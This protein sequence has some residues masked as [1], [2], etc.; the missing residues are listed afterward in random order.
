MERKG[1]GRDLKKELVSAESR[2]LETGM[3][4]A[5]SNFEPEI[6]IWGVK[7]GEGG[8]ECWNV[9]ATL[10]GTHTLRTLKKKC[11]KELTDSI[12]NW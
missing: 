4:G 12:P 5:S 10:L 8:L 3:R 11:I 9:W 2:R 7:E 6:L 1:E